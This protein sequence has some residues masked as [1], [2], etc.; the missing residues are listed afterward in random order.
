MLAR[1]VQDQDGQFSLRRLYWRQVLCSDGADCRERLLRV[2]GKFVRTCGEQHRHR[3]PVQHR[4]HGGRWRYMREMRA[5][6]VQGT[7]IP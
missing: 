4:K 5:G 2:P 6:Q 3:L 1:Q 7:D